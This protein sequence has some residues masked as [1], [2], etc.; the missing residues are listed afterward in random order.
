MLAI[1]GTFEFE[2]AVTDLCAHT[3]PI[4]YMDIEGCYTHIGI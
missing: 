1:R 3:E 4:E 2:D